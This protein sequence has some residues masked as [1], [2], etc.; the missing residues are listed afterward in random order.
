[1][2]RFASRESILSIG[3]LLA[4]AVATIAETPWW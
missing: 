2:K 4:I 1:M 3:V